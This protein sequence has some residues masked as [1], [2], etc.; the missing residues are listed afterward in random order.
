MRAIRQDSSLHIHSCDKTW[1]SGHFSNLVFYKSHMDFLG[2]N[3][4]M[5][6]RKDN[7][8]QNIDALWNLAIFPYLPASKFP[9]NKTKKRRK[10]N[11]EGSILSTSKIH[12]IQIEGI[13][14]TYNLYVTLF[15]KIHFSGLRV[16]F[17]TILFCGF[18]PQNRYGSI[19]LSQKN[20]G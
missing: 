16:F 20:V 4:V 14:I 17:S 3:D 2:Y 13:I 6:P 5:H 15:L 10:K 18:N 11:S 8:V 19:F 7:R 9:Q 12:L 1:S